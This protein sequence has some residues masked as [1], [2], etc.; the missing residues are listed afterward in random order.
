MISSLNAL[1]QLTKHLAYYEHVRNSHA[2]IVC[3]DVK[4]FEFH[5]KGE[6]VVK[7]WAEGFVL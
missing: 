7:V 1:P 5:K 2:M 4:R 6:G 3:R